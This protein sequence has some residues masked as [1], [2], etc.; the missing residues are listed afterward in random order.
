MAKMKMFILFVLLL[1]AILKVELDVIRV[2]LVTGRGADSV[3]FETD[4]G[5][6]D[7]KLPKGSGEDFL[8]MN[9]PTMEYELIEVPQYK[10]D[11]SSRKN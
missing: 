7:T 11:F 1:G 9:Y 3:S 10:S 4:K 2:T 6:W 8:K 5:S